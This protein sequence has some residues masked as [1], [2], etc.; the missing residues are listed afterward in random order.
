ML[1]TITDEVGDQTPITCDSGEMAERIGRWFT[2]SPAEVR[3]VLGRVQRYL[4]AGLNAD[5]W[6]NYLGIR[7]DPAVRHEGNA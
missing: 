5:G 4:D 1:I 2:D 6:A 7:I 3:D